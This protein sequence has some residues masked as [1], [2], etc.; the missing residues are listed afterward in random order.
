MFL[1]DCYW[2]VAAHRDRKSSA[3]SSQLVPNTHRETPYFWTPLGLFDAELKMECVG[4]S[5]TDNA[6]PWDQQRSAKS[7]CAATESIEFLLGELQVSGPV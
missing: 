7:Y 6:M 4:D 3:R 1:K 5:C 2:P